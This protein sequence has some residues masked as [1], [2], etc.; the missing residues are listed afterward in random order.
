VAVDDTDDTMPATLQRKLFAK[1]TETPSAEEGVPTDKSAIVR[2]LSPE[3]DDDD[4]NL[5][6]VNAV[7]VSGSVAAPMA[8]ATT[9]WEW[10]CAEH[11]WKPYSHEVSAQLEA[12][13]VAGGSQRVDV[14]AT[15]THYVDTNSM[16]Q[17]R[18]D[19][20]SRHRRVR[21]VAG[22]A[23]LLSVADKIVAGIP[24]D[25]FNSKYKPA[26]DHAEGK[27]TME[28]IES[29]RL[30]IQRMEPRLPTPELISN[31]HE[32]PVQD[33]ADIVSRVPVGISS[34]VPGASHPERM[35]SEAIWND[36]RD[37][38]RQDKTVPE[39]LADERRNDMFEHTSAA[40]FEQ[41]MR[42]MK[43]DL[44][45]RPHVEAADFFAPLGSAEVRRSASSS[46]C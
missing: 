19:D 31:A 29:S 33:V 40:Q 5:T 28:T 15:H 30:N 10:Q 42:L 39:Q 35:T 1:S 18:H 9:S 3:G 37:H 7:A 20:H 8:E 11:T 14:D 2:V 27:R 13:C 46:C 16:R 44:P 24:S 23:Q 25:E 6:T 45:N 43:E 12:A 36:S 22:G 4:V 41:A 26:T 21:R 34:V 32:S 38:F 17:V